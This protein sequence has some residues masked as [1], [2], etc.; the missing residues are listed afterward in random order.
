MKTLKIVSLFIISMIV[1]A[2]VGLAFGS[3]LVIGTVTLAFLIMQGLSFSRKNAAAYALACGSL[4]TAFAANCNTKPVA[5]LEVDVYLMNRD[6]IDLTLTVPVGRNIPSITMQSGKFVYKFSGLKSSNSSSI[7]MNQGKYDN[8]WVHTWAGVIFD[9]TAATKE[10]IIEKLAA[11]NIVAVV[12]NKWKG[13]NSNMEFEVLGWDVGLDM[14]AGEKKSD[15]ADTQNS[16]K[17][18]MTSP[19]DQFETNAGYILWD[20]NQAT[21]LAALEAITSG[22]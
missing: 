22:S 19:K 21:T 18:S 8:N 9:N 15:D 16:W 5:G 4:A 13:S 10:D 20:T 6:E 17:V 14:S 11:A 12:R 1:A 3:L 2:Y 7:I